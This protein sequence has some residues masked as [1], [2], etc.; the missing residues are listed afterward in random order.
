LYE[1]VESMVDIYNVD[2]LESVYYL[3]NNDYLEEVHGDLI[4]AIQLAQ[5]RYYQDVADSY[6]P[7]LF[8]F[9]IYNYEAPNTK[10][11]E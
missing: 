6:M 10:E 11:E 2:L 1:V 8:D 4:K 7:Q 5:Y 3:W 9:F